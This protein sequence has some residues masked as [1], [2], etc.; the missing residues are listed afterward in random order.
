MFIINSCVGYGAASDC[1]LQLTMICLVLQKGVTLLSADRFCDCMFGIL[2]T[3]Q[4]LYRC[5]APKRQ[6]RLLVGCR[7]LWFVQQ[8]YAVKIKLAPRNLT[9]LISRK[10]SNANIAPFPL[11]PFFLL[12]SIVRG[13]G[14]K[15]IKGRRKK[16]QSSKKNLIRALFM[17]MLVH[18]MVSLVSLFPVFCLGVGGSP[19]N[20]LCRPIS[21]L[22]TYPAGSGMLLSPSGNSFAM[23]L[24]SRIPMCLFLKS[25][26]SLQSLFD[27]TSFSSLLV[28]KTFSTKFFE[29]SHL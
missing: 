20:S 26:P 13:L 24:N 22:T 3:I 15:G 27:E 19:Y 21:K 12:L 25:T 14:R 5:Q 29:V 2:G 17:P 23:L 6:Y 8:S 4:R 9:A 16:P 18:V 10:Q 7:L 1:P 11:Y 28:L